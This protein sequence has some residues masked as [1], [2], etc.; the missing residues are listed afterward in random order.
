MEKDPRFSVE[1]IFIKGDI[2]AGI[3]KIEEF[4]NLESETLKKQDLNRMARYFTR[5]EKNDAAEAIL[6][7]ILRLDQESSSSWYALG[8][9][10]FEIGRNKDA[11]D[12]LQRA[13]SR[14]FRYYVEYN[15]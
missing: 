14:G 1:K 9:F 5:R 6:K 2:D 4:N 7:Y 13:N 3:Q 11:L 12:S 10:Y 8:R 15:R